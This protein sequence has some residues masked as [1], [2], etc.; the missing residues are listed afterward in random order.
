MTQNSLPS[1]SASTMCPSSG[2][3]PTSTWL[4]P[5]VERLR[6]HPMLVSSIR[7]GQVQVSPVLRE[8]V[9]AAAVEGQPHL[10]G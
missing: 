10:R 7:A 1:G 9:L 4:A 6:N 2:R 3:C 5:Q 8:A